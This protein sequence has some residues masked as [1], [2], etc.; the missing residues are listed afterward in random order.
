[1]IIFELI[2]WPKKPFLRLQARQRNTL[3]SGLSTIAVWQYDRKVATFERK[4]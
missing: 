2:G 4:S 3:V 1:M